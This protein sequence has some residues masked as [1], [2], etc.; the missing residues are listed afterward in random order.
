MLGTR[1]G[2][3]GWTLVALLIALPAAAKKPKAPKEAPAEAPAQATQ[4]G[5]EPTVQIGTTSG[6]TL[7]V[8]CGY[9]AGDVHRYE[10]VKTEKTTQPGLAQQVVSYRFDMTFTIVSHEGDIT[11][12]DLAYS[13]LV[14]TAAPADAVQAAL[15]EEV[16][17]ASAMAP[18]RLEI[19]HA[20]RV[21]RIHNPDE[22]TRTGAAMAVQIKAG[23]AK[24]LEGAP[25]EVLAQV[26]AMV[27]QMVTN[28]ALL[29]QG[30][31]EDVIPTFGFSCATLPAG[32]TTY[33]AQFPNPLGGPPLSGNGKVTIST[34][35]DGNVVVTDGTTLDP[36][37]VEAVVGP[38]LAQAGMEI[39]PELDGPLMDLSNGLDLTL[40]GVDG[41]PMRW[42]SFK[43]VSMVGASKLDQ[44]QVTRVADPSGTLAR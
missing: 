15:M 20:S 26:S 41:W 28:P 39:P 19:D 1:A 35:K 10:A 18:L 11:L 37:A 31:L 12:V 16:G 27:E 4:L 13:P 7:D 5:Q 2:R 3:L 9:A 21:Q 33:A 17:A 34:G 23:L 22:L 40:S 14:F 25:P 30:V 8:P 43:S 32:E 29:Q 6:A 42:T 44:Q 36:V 24:R 38:M